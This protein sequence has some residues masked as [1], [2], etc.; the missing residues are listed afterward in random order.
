MALG[1]VV[2]VDVRRVSGQE[3]FRRS[4][5]LRAS[6]A[7]LCDQPPCASISVPDERDLAVSWLKWRAARWRAVFDLEEAKLHCP[8][9]SRGRLRTLHWRSP[10]NSRALPTI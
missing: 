5:F 3:A 7:R 2:R 4:N 1:N 8:R 9:R 10:L 6:H